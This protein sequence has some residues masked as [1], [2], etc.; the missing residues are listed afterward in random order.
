MRYLTE[1]QTESLLRA[2]QE[3][4]NEL[5]TQVE[6][7]RER[8]MEMYV[9]LEG[10]AGDEADQA[11]TKIRAGIENELIDRHVRELA[12]LE[13][14]RARVGRG[15]FGTCMEC[16]GPIGFER[17]K[18]YPAALRCADCQAQREKTFAGTP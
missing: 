9:Q 4:E 15:T 6:R 17:L 10:V 1:R 16:G 3:R 8:A 14:A 18:A 11:L 7:E 2:M 12:A 5:R 13:E